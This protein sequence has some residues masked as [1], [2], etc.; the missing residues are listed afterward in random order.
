MSS[1]MPAALRLRCGR[2]GAAFPVSTLTALTTVARHSLIGVD[3][4]AS[5]PNAYMEKNCFISRLWHED[6]GPETGSDDHGPAHSAL[7]DPGLGCP[8][9]GSDRSGAVSGSAAAIQQQAVV[10]TG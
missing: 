7:Q 4:A 1:K 10:A 9:G 6:C 5:S 2:S 3:P 8:F